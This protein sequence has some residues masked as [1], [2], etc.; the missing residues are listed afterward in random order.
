MA[1]TIRLEKDE[2]QELELLKEQLGL[3]ASSK[4]ISHLIL[5]FRRVKFKMLEAEFEL[6]ATKEKL[7]CLCLLIK[8]REN[9][10]KEISNYVQHGGVK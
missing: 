8:K 6:N 2:E 4:I 5:N 10:E 7:D 1:L 3:K 9:L